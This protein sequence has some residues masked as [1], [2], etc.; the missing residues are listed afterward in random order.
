M[1]VE[2]WQVTTELE[3]DEE[4]EVPSLS[5][6]SLLQKP[7]T[8]HAPLG[9]T[10][11]NGASSNGCAATAAAKTRPFAALF[12]PSSVFARLKVDTSPGK[13]TGKRPGAV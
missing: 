7:A 8:A 5:G 12:E 9:P 6:H 1:S 3:S 11:G 13:P 10:S 2:Q 4:G